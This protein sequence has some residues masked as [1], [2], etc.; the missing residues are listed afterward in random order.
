MPVFVTDQ[1]KKW[2]CEQKDHCRSLGR[3]E[4]AH[5]STETR[6][7]LLPLAQ[8][9]CL[10]LDHD[11][12]IRAFRWKR[13]QLPV[14]RHGSGRQQRVGVRGHTEVAGDVASHPYAKD[15]RYR[16]DDP[17][18]VQTHKADVRRLQRGAHATRLPQRPRLSG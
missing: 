17:L 6:S 10:A 12:D 9:R 4:Q 16:Q 3:A 8:L 11:D 14:A 18:C 2:L 13:R 15:D 7:S 5:L 1:A